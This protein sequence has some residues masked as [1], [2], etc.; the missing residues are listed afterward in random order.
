MNIDVTSSISLDE[1]GEQIL[2]N[3]TPKQFSEWIF[4][5]VDRSDWA[6]EIIPLIKKGADKYKL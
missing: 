4:E 1:I 3:L 6:E 5:T 2:N